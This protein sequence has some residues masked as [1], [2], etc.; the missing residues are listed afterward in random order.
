MINAVIIP[1]III[2]D[3]TAMNKYVVRFHQYGRNILYHSCVIGLSANRL[4][5]SRNFNSGLSITILL[6][7]QITTE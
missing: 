5:L 2:Y 6:C 3:Q 1:M 4:L 7:V